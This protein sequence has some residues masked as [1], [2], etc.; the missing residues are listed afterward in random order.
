[1]GAERGLDGEGRREGQPGVRDLLVRRKPHKEQKALVLKVPEFS[2]ETSFSALGPVCT[3]G[4]GL[5]TRKGPGVPLPTSDLPP[6][7]P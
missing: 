7:H 3:E 5:D 2:S 4:R 6:P 1:M